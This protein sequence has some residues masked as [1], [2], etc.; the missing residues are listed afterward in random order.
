MGLY[1]EQKSLFETTNV[2]VGLLYTQMGL[3]KLFEPTNAVV[4]YAYTQMGF[5]QI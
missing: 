3:N 4:L 5:V 1:C 2:D